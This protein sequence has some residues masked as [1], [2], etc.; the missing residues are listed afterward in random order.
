VAN[1]EVVKTLPG[2][3]RRAGRSCPPFSACRNPSVPRSRSPLS[4]HGNK[5][6]GG[7]TMSAP[8]QGPASSTASRAAAAGS[9]RSSARPVRRSGPVLGPPPHRAACVGDPLS[10]W[11]RPAHLRFLLSQLH[12]HGRWAGEPDERPAPHS[13]N[14]NA[15]L[16]H[17]RDDVSGLGRSHCSL[18]VRSHQADI[19][20]PL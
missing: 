14:R 18:D 15:G 1:A 13:T 4:R 3:P 7:V 12:E 20:P 6:A 17:V 10:R 11:S 5:T 16:F 2:H 9:A 19:G 8:L